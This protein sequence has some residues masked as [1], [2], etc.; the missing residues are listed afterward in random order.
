MH[1][2]ISKLSSSLIGCDSIKD[3]EL[4]IAACLKFDKSW[5][6]LNYTALLSLKSHSEVMV[7]G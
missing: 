7:T 2:S 4:F 1:N 5:Q 3:A 6:N